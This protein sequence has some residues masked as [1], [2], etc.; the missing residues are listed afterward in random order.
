MGPEG[1][2]RIGLRVAAGAVAGCEITSTRPDIAG[3]LLKGRTPADITAI[4]PRLFTLCAASQAAACTLALGAAAGQRADRQRLAELHQAVV[5]ERLSETALRVLLQWPLALG[6]APSE[7]AVAAARH[8]RDGLANAPLASALF[9]RP[10]ADW[11]DLTTPAAWWDWA[12]EGRTAAGRWVAANRSD[13]EAPTAGVALLPAHPE[14]AWWSELAQHVLGDRDFERQPHWRGSAAETGALARQAQDPLVAALLARDARA[15]ARV[16]A[17]LRELA[18][19][20]VA[21]SDAAM[22]L[23]GAL[24]LGDGIGLGWAET[25]RGRLMHLVQLGAGRATTYRIVAPTEWNFHPRGALVAALRGASASDAA[26]LKHRAHVLVEGLDPC[27][28]CMVEV[29]D[30]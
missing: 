28:A 30:A 24:S 21:P 22:T 8:A 15:A 4:V 20:L 17:R 27:V 11:L 2:I 25:A 7:D 5:R 3:N 1:A 29:V 12:A 18:H 13:L 9:G 14:G 6:E 23:V 10:A 16:A 19:A 26:A